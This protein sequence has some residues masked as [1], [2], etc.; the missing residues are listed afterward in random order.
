MTTFQVIREQNYRW[1]NVQVKITNGFQMFDTLDDYDYMVRLACKLKDDLNNLHWDDNNL[2]AVM[3]A[4]NPAKIATL[5]LN[6]PDLYRIVVSKYT[7]DQI[8]L[9][10]GYDPSQFMMYIIAYLYIVC[11]TVD[12]LDRI[13]FQIELDFE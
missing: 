6:E 5:M 13:P 2:N 7:N 8:E 3:M 10:Q 1:K 4:I 12:M 11:P 9:P